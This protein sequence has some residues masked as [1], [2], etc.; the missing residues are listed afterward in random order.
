MIYYSCYFR[1]EQIQE[2][3]M[4]DIVK[5]VIATIVAGILSTIVVFV[6]RALGF[7][8]EKSIVAA[9]L[10]L[11]VLLLLYFFFVAIRRSYPRWRRHFVLHFIHKALQE[12][13][14]QAD[15]VELKYNI[16][17][18]VTRHLHKVRENESYLVRVFQNQK[19]CEAEIKE[20]FRRAKRTRILTIR[21]ENYFLSKNSLLNEI[22]LSKRGDGFSIRVLVLIPESSHINEKLARTLDHSATDI[23][24]KMHRA[25]DNLMHMAEQ[26]PNFQI[27]CYNEPP[28]FKLLLFDDVMFFSVYLRAKNDLNTPMLRITREE[29]VL[30]SGLEKEFED[31]WE[32][33]IKP[34]SIIDGRV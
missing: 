32:R 29:P 11:L 3:L 25:L 13:S 21:G 6:G 27:R 17:D 33:A 10:A 28:N 1:A 22:A 31:L 5:N 16:I 24:R 7:D 23:K 34:E 12:Q 26:N 9:V 30:F 8:T 19:Q 18:M 2:A 15:V 4:K 20:T 14:G